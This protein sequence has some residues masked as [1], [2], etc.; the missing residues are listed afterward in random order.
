MLISWLVKVA[1]VALVGW[2]AWTAFRP[3][4][5]L[6]IVVNKDGVQF[7]T[8][9]P[10]AKRQ[11]I[12]GFRENDV[13]IENRVTILGVRGRDG[14]VR[15]EFRGRLHPSIRQRIRNYLKLNV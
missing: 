12:V 9:L 7:S 5:A 1:F 10:A 4:H 11:Q 14:I 6:R 15:Y 13:E 2:L 8:G 3:R